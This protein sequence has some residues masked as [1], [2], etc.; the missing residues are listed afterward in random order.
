MSLKTWKKEFYP[1]TAKQA[2]KK[3]VVEAV[4]HSL[5]KWT[6][7]KK[8]NLEKHDVHQYLASIEYDDYRVS[9]S[10]DDSSCAL[11]QKFI[12]KNDSCYGCPLYIVRGENQCD[13][14]V[15]NENPYREWTH[16]ENPSLMIKYLRKALKWAK[17]NS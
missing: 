9:M 1:I 11:C 14:T 7:L 12:A 17:E 3:S 13:W 10:I 16:N 15:K 8:S 2:A 4:E 5:T 6:G